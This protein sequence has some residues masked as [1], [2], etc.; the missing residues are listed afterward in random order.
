[1]VSCRDTN[2]NI[3]NINGNSITVMGHG[4]MGFSNLYPINTAE[5]ILK[6]INRGADGS[7]IDIQLTKDNILVAFHDPFLEAST[8]FTGR[9]RDYTWEE[10]QKACYNVTPLHEYKL[11]RISELFIGLDN[12]NELCF[13][14]DI[15]LYQ[16]GN[17]DQYLEDYTDALVGLYDQFSI[18]NSVYVESQSE[19]FFNLLYSKDPQIELYFYAQDFESGMAMSTNIDLKGITISNGLINADQIAQAHAQGLFVTL[20][21]VTTKGEN[22]DAIHKSP[23]MIQTDKVKYLV[24]VLK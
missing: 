5:S 22:I 18:H 21:D 8:D 20:W 23:D 11:L 14:F 13:T 1:M 6:C 17:Y 24:K 7:E 2:F 9:I 16:D 15:K 19:G 3:E 4:G 12:L 10:L